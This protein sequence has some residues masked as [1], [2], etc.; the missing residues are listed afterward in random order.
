VYPVA[1]GNLFVLYIRYAVVLIN[2]YPWF[3]STGSPS[4][5]KDV[6]DEFHSFVFFVVYY[7]NVTRRPFVIMIINSTTWLVWN[8][9]INKKMITNGLLVGSSVWIEIMYLKLFYYMP[10]LVPFGYSKFGDE[11][12][13]LK[14]ENTNK[15]NPAFAWPIDNKKKCLAL[16]MCVILSLVTWT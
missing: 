2:T 10:R 3:D 16:V 14:M 5:S 9:I 15:V 11:W 4:Y 1:T 12:F 8:R 7:D 6:Q 13:C